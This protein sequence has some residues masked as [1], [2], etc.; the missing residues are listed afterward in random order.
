MPRAWR[1]RLIVVAAL[2]IGGLAGC[3][4]R[5][6]VLAVGVTSTTAATTDAVATTA[7][8]TTAAA[9]TSTGGAA[10]TI[11][12]A[13]TPTT[14]VAAGPTTGGSPTA[15]TS[16][17]GAPVAASPSCAVP[18]DRPEPTLPDGEVVV[19]TA[20][21][22]RM[23]HPTA[24]PVTEVNVAADQVLPR[25]LLAEIGLDGN[26]TMQPLVVRNPARYPGL[27]VF[28]FRRPQ[29]DLPTTAEL[30]REF[31]NYRKFFVQPKTISGCV[32]GA[33]A[34]GLLTTNQEYLQ[35]IWTF[36]RD[37]A[38][39]VALGLA[40]DDGTSRGQNAAV[41]QFT[42]ILRTVRWLD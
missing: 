28:R 12:R 14:R 36:Y 30:L 40:V 7:V 22:L 20:L 18:R 19:A 29:V 42:A 34:L 3:S 25:A 11:R 15:P 13:G 9:S 27:A 38:M 17:P 6:Q 41:D 4:G 8:A 2:G 35:V 24:W 39:Y 31:A 1:R 33:P 26:T 32:D 16:A 5:E 37:D 23:A 10:T 21:G